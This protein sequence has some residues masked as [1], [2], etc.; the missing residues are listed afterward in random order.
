MGGG[1]G[2]AGG[3][4]DEHDDCEHQCEQPQSEEGATDREA[5]FLEGGELGVG[6]E[7]CVRTSQYS[8]RRFATRLKNTGARKM[9]PTR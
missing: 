3:C 4:E 1:I 9:D 7:P 2:S 6:R 5:G 8:L